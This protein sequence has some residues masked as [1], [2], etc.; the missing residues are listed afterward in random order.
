MKYTQ[1]DKDILVILWNSSE[2][3]TA[4][5][6]VKK[7]EDLT[8]NT[9][10]AVLR[11]LLN[12]HLIE[13]ADIVYSG[14]VLSRRYQPCVTRE[15]FLAFQ[16]EAETAKMDREIRKSAFVAALF[17]QEEDTEKARHEIEELETM[18]EEFKKKL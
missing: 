11:K 3:L 10:Q 7:R 17:E 13:V 6:I 16:F 5:G 15:E 9:V 18:L 8:A 4:S 2:P 14:T 1:R 12:N